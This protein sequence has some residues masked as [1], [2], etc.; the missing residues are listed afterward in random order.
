MAVNGV[1]NT[2]AAIAS[3]EGMSFSAEVTKTES[4][5]VSYSES[6]AA[7]FE[8]SEEAQKLTEEKGADKAK[9]AKEAKGPADPKTLAKMLKDADERTAAMKSLV[10]KLLLKQGNKLEGPLDL[11]SGK[12]GKLADLYKGLEVDEAT[13]AQA[14]EDISEDGYW[15]IEQTSD[16]ILE[17]AQALAGDDP[18][19]ANKML[20]A[21]K[22][23]FEE[24]GKAWGEDLPDISNKTMDKTLEK[25]NNWINGLNGGSDASSSNGTSVSGAVASSKSFSYEHT[26]TTSV[27]VSASYAKV[28]S[29]SYAKQMEI[30]DDKK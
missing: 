7:V 3:Y 9:T 6:K 17:F 29:A 27:K 16:R 14:Q 21:I 2:N 23:G 19:M 26:T 28:A 20:D 30:S 5:K 15:G 18:E 8:M 24:A 1:T 11:F 25:V 4:T 12:N 10:E 13:R 22:K